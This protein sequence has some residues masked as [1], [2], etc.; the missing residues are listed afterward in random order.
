MLDQN[1]AQVGQP[2]PSGF[3]PSPQIRPLMESCLA[4]NLP[5]TRRD[6]MQAPLTGHLLSARRF[7]ST[8]VDPWLSPT[9]GSISVWATGYEGGDVLDV[10]LKLT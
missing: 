9:M 5:D 4:G 3:F 7:I 1:C 8:P 6:R 2:L 10:L